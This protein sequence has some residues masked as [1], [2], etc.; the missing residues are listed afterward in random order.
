VDLQPPQRL[1][2]DISLYTCIGNYIRG[3]FTRIADRSDGAAQ[4]RFRRGNI[5]APGEQPLGHPYYNCGGC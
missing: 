5:Y 1:Q 4:W 3:N 2:G